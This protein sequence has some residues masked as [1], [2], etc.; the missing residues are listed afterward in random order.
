MT[1]KKVVF[2]NSILHYKI[3]ETAGKCLMFVHGFGEDWRVWEHQIEAL[4]KHYNLILPD[5]FGSGDSDMLEGENISI[6]D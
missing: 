6:D 2:K 3:S 5:I 4:S 1:S